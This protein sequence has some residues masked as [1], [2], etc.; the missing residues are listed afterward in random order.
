VHLLGAR[1]YAELP[2]VLRG[3]DAAMI[4]YAV[5]ELTSSVFPMK[6]YEYLSAGLPV[7]ATPLPSLEGVEGVTIASGAPELAERL[8]RLVEEDDRERR[9]ARSA[10]AARHSW[11]T[12]LE[13]IAAAFERLP[14]RG[15]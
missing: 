5:N 11:D 15:A 2:D 1:A 9:A 6:V 4:P 12:R 10:L 3:A 13:E 8:S 14:E 7:V